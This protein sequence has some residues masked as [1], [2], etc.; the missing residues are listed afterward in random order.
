MS[1]G[2]KVSEM[3][4][5]LRDCLFTELQMN[6]NPPAETCLISGEDGRTFLSIGLGEDRCCAGFAWVRVARVV[7]RLPLSDAEVT[8]CGIDVWGADYEM[9][10]ARCA[11]WG[12]ASAGPTCT[13]M[14]D[15]AVQV[16]RDAEA[17]RRA[18]CCFRPQ[19][20]SGRMFP[21]EWLP[22]G[23]EGGCGGG[24]MGV[25]IQIDDCDCDN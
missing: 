6:P 14:T 9:G 17:M 20:D 15:H 5:L 7:P 12:S 22:F 25:S 4:L 23:P 24:I 11:P 21:T 10:V 3:A 13:Q 8:N 19:V 1:L 16:Q 2:D 18:L